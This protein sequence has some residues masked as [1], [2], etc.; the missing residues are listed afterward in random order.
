MKPVVSSLVALAIALS[1]A[2]ALAAEKSHKPVASKVVKHAHVQKKSEKAGKERPSAIAQVKHVK[3]DEAKPAPA[4]MKVAHVSKET[5][6]SS[7]DEP[8]HK[9]EPKAEHGVTVIPASLMTKVKHVSTAHAKPAELPKLPA[10][11]ANA[12][13]AGAKNASEKGVKKPS[14]KKSADASS[15]DG[16]TERDEELAD[17]VAR[18]RGQKATEPKSDAKG[19]LV[20]AEKAEKAPPPCVKPPVEMSRGS[21]VDT[22]EL[23][24]CDGSIAPLAVEHLSVLVRPGNAERPA[25]PLAELAKKKGADLA[26]GIKRIDPGLVTRLAAVAEH[27]AKAASPVKLSVVSGYRPASVGSLHQSG[28]AMDFRVEGVKNEEVVAFCKTLGDTGCG[29][30]PNSSFV[31]VDVRDPGAGHVSW[32][33]AS[34]PGETPRYVAMWPPPPEPKQI[35]DEGTKGLENAT[36]LKTDRDVPP[37][38]PV[39]DHP[40]EAS[41]TMQQ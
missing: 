13:P 4:I 12:K 1:P 39:D 8:G 41:E 37:S 22:F 24:K 9:G 23:T 3:K 27:F 25:S 40:A 14:E 10:P 6:K 36:A 20:K 5:K 31:H 38:E 28:R 34:G 21:E 17:L 11:A 18:I 16:Q 35:V 15:D 2:F 33:D 30:Y 7:H 29:Y 19:K 26:R 32:I